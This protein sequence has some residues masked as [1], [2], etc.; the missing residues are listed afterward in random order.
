M[1]KH[2]GTFEEDFEPP[3]QPPK[4]IDD[5]EDSKPDDWIDDEEMDDPEDSKP[6]DWDEDAPRRIKDPEKSMP[7][8]WHPDEKKKIQDPEAER[9]DDWDDEDDGEFEAPL[10][11][12]PLCTEECGCEEWPQPMMLNP[13]YKG[14]WKA[15]RIPNPDYIGE[16]AKKKIPNPAYYEVTADT[17]RINDI[18]HV[19]L[20]IWTMSKNMGFDNILLGND[21]E[22]A[23]RFAQSTF[24]VK[25][26]LDEKK[27]EKEAEENAA[28]KAEAE[29]WIGWA[30]QTVMQNPAAF[31]LSLLVVVI[32]TI[33]FCFCSGDDEEVPNPSEV[34]ELISE[35]AA[36]P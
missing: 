29:G 14:K 28:A 22:G 9:P 4:E 33:Y 15:Q 16:W 8:C 27:A 19:A 18:S 24:S 6:D 32:T 26:A 23:D 2:K 11:D 25:K 36:E 31:G 10:V 13:D 35:T 7:E 30:K 34:Q 17:I 1:G 21:I 3:I 5:P 20:D 12:N